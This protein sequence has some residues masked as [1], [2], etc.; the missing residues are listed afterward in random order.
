[1]QRKLSIE[2][3]LFHGVFSIVSIA[4]NNNFSEVVFHV[5]KQYQSRHTGGVI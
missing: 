5:N 2:W 1:M 3:L 4:W